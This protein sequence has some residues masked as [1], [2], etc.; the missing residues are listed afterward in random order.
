M[1]ITLNNP[2]QN[3]TRRPRGAALWLRRFRQGSFSVAH[4][5]GEAL[6]PDRPLLARGAR[7][8]PGGRGGELPAPL[9]EPKHLGNTPTQASF[10]RSGRS[11]ATGCG[12][13]R[14]SFLSHRSGCYTGEMVRN[15][16]F[17]ALDASGTPGAPDRSAPPDHRAWLHARPPREVAQIPPTPRFL[18]GCVC[19]GPLGDTYREHPHDSPGVSR[20]LFAPG[21]GPRRL[22][23][24]HTRPGTHRKLPRTRRPGALPLAPGRT[25][26]A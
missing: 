13:S 11:P 10:R 3:R 19:Q 21:R 20:L 15:M 25:E 16:T 7:G 2:Y 12:T 17:R 6:G 4:D 1:Q 26:P 14:S 9:R 5:R 23:R 22:L 18:G 8:Q 24:T